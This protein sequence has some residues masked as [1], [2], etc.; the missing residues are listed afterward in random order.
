MCVFLL[1]ISDIP[2]LKGEVHQ[3]LDNQSIRQTDLSISF[4]PF[5]LY[6]LVFIMCLCVL[7]KTG[8]TTL[9]SLGVNIG[10]GGTTV[11]QTDTH[12]HTILSNTMLLICKCLLLCC[13]VCG[14][15][16][17]CV[18]AYIMCLLVCAYVSVGVCV[19][20]TCGLSL[21]CNRK[22]RPWGKQTLQALPTSSHLGE[23]RE[24]EE[25]ERGKDWE[26]EKP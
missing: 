17:V 26:R 14:S 8:I 11:H 19:L 5:S 22:R 1:D 4:P 2:L 18:H 15:V 25:E 24:G 10:A 12:T 6:Y 16:V 23:R 21:Q 9:P 7:A 20:S 13:T 3:Q